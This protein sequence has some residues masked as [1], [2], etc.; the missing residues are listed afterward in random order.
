MVPPCVPLFVGPAE[1]T[2]PAAT[3]PLKLACYLRDQV[4]GRGRG[5]RRGPQAVECL[6]PRPHFPVLLQVE[7]AGHGLDVGDLRV[8]TIRELENRERAAVPGVGTAGERQ[9]LQG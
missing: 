5:E 3:A 1:A 6:Y 4:D 2:P 8:G 7:V 9:H